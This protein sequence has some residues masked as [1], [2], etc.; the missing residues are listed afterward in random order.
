MN[1]SLDRFSLT[2][3]K[4]IIRAIV[5]D[6]CHLNLHILTTETM[7]VTKNLMIHENTQA[8]ILSGSVNHA[9]KNCCWLS[10]TTVAQIQRLNFILY[11]AMQA[12]GKIKEPI[13]WL[14][15]R[16]WREAADLADII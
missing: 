4:Q 8:S 13:N 3:E 1:L 15:Q 16:L 6:P 7:P 10:K 5:R 12:L 11:Q 9:R 14:V 2:L